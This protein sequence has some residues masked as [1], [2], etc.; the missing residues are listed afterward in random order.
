MAQ[1]RGGLASAVQNASF[2]ISDTPSAE[3]TKLWSGFSSSEGVHV[4]VGIEQ[5]CCKLNHLNVTLHKTIGSPSKTQHSCSP[6]ISGLKSTQNSFTPGFICPGIAKHLSS[7]DYSLFFKMFFREGKKM[8]KTQ[9]TS[10]IS[11][12]LSAYLHLCQL[13]FTQILIL[14][15]SLWKPQF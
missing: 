11:T 10:Q 8:K 4:N 15:K 14:F 9:S 3:A 7:E 2:C 5:T 12:L 6:Q 1:R 13:L